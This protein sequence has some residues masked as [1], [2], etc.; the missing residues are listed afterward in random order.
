LQRDKKTYQSADKSDALHITILPP[1]PAP[2]G[3]VMGLRDGMAALRMGVLSEAQ[4]LAGIVGD[5]NYSEFL[6]KVA[7]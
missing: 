3:D 2:E 5:S 4:V 7:P 6:N 1:V